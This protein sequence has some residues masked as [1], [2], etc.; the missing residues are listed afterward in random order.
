MS[1][2]FTSPCGADDI[3]SPQDI[4]DGTSSQTEKMKSVMESLELMA[5]QRSSRD[6]LDISTFT[7][8]QRDKLLEIMSKNEDHAF[9]YNKQRLETSQ[10][11]NSEIIASSI[12]TQKTIRII[13]ILAI[14]VIVILLLIILFAKDQYFI[15]FLT[16][17]TGLL[18]GM[19]LQ[20]FIKSHASKPNLINKDDE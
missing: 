1:D 16:F 10:K 20:G 2:D 6:N 17:I 14:C 4:L 18:S 13:S 19:G 3:I 7:D 5:M 12:F 11:I 15:P 8:S 9:A